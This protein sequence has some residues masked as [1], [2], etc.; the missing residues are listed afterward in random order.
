MFKAKDS[1]IIEIQTDFRFLW[2]DGKQPYKWLKIFYLN[3]VQ[4]KTEKQKASVTSVTVNNV[5]SEITV[6]NV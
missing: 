3:P 1:R 2:C 4:L 6:N 5:E